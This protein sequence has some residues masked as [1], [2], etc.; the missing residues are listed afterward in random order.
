M[1]CGQLLVNSP[2]VNKFLFTNYRPKPRREPRNK[3][4]CV[5]PTVRLVGF[6]PGAI[7]FNCL[8]DIAKPRLENLCSKCDLNTSGHLNDVLK[9]EEIKI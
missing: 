4:G 5:I 3:V 2:D 8:T 1:P 7:R 9:T 6:K